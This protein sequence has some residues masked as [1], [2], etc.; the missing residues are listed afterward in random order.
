MHG[1]TQTHTHWQVT[2]PSLFAM[3]VHCICR[4]LDS[5]FDFSEEIFNFLL[6]EN[7]ESLLR[8]AI[9]DNSNF[10]VARS[11]LSIKAILEGLDRQ[12]GCI[13]NVK[14]VRV[15]LLEESLG[16]CGSAAQGSCLP[17]VESS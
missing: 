17:A 7:F 1:T 13:S 9:F 6:A 10:N 15:G 4:T 11:H 2:F 8:I 3:S 16:F 12:V 5:S 14:I